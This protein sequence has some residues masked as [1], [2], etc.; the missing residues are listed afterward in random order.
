ML[1]INHREHLKFTYI[2]T[3][4][5]IKRAFHTF[6]KGLNEVHKGFKQLNHTE[7][8]WKDPEFKYISVDPQHFGTMFT[9]EVR[10]VISFLLQDYTVPEVFECGAE[11][12]L[13]MREISGRI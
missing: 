2:D 6:H 10:C 8:F 7:G 3:A 4:G 13:A 1:D 11:L 5:C 9:V 12:G